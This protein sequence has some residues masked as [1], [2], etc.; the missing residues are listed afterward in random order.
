MFSKKSSTGSDPNKVSTANAASITKVATAPNIP[1][2][3]KI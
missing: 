3:I 2:K 1:E